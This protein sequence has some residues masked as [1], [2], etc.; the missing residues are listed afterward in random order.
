MKKLIP[1]SVLAAL[2][3]PLT[4]QESIPHIFSPSTPAKA[5]EVNENFDFLNSR[6]NGLENSSLSGDS[7]TQEFEVDCTENPA[8]LSEA[9][10]ANRFIENVG[11]LITGSCYGDITVPRV[12]GEAAAQV[13]GQVIF[14]TGAD[15]SATLID[16]DLTGNINLWASFGGGLYLRDLAVVTS[17]GIPVGFSRNGHGS[18]INVS[19]SRSDGEA[20]AGVFVQEGGQVYLGDVAINGFEA[21]IAARNGAVIRS[22]G[23]I[24]IANVNTGISLQNSSFRGSNNINISAAD[25]ALQLEVKSTWQGWGA[26]LSIAQG[27]LSIDSGSSLVGTQILAPNAEIN[28]Y[29]SVLSGEG[30]TAN[31][32]RANGSMVTLTNSAFTDEVVSEHNAKLEFYDSPLNNVVVHQNSSFIF[33]GASIA[34]MSV[35]GNSHTHLGN[36]SVANIETSLGSTVDLYQTAIS[37]RVDVYANSTFSANESTFGES[38]FLHTADG[39]H[40]ALLGGSIINESQSSCYGGTLEVEGVDVNAFNNGCLNTGGYQEMIDFFKSARNN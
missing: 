36:T 38:S 15:E 19:I 34:N 24:S 33:G 23:D 18:V 2:S 13:H 31:N 4:A 37:G 32:L 5:A 20:Y 1:L 9:Y 25:Q 3:T 14:I 29:H 8:A 35:N 16:N 30:V 27:N 12:E 7:G 6:L 39:G 26:N 40:S 10:L 11:F 28:V 17:G 22:V 21:G